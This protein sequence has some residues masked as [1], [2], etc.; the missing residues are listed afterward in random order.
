MKVV[1]QS[2]PSARER[3]RPRWPAFT[4]PRDDYVIALRERLSQPQRVARDSRVRESRVREIECYMQRWRVRN[5]C[6]WVSKH[7]SG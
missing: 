5:R 1:L 3:A 2:K 4:Q 6:R 7:P